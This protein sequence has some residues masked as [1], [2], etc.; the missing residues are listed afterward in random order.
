MSSNIQGKTWAQQLREDMSFLYEDEDDDMNYIIHREIKIGSIMQYNNNMF[1]AA[2]GTGTLE[3][4]LSIG[5]VISEQ[6]NLQIDCIL[7]SFITDEPIKIPYMYINKQSCIPAYLKDLFDRYCNKYKRISEIDISLLNLQV[8]SIAI[9][10]YMLKSFN[11]LKEN[12]ILIQGEEKTLQFFKRIYK[13]GI[14]AMHKNR[15]YKWLPKENLTR[16]IKNL[17]VLTSIELMPIFTIEHDYI[18]NKD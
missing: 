3:S 2:V 4:N 17:E 12:M 8:P 5:L 18:S 11:V 13:N 16:E 15:Y 6:T 9:L 1:Q 7:K 10:D 14:F